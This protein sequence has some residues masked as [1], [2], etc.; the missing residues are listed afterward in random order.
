MAHSIP[1]RRKTTGHEMNL[2][3]QPHRKSYSRC[4]SISQLS[5]EEQ[6]KSLDDFKFYGAYGH[7][8]KQLDYSYHQYYR[9]ERQWLHDSIIEEYLRGANADPN[10]LPCDPWL[11]LTVGCQGAG[12]RYVIE[13]LAEENRLPLLSIV[14]VD[15]EE[16]RQLLP[17]YSSYTADP[18]LLVEDLTQKECGYIAETLTLAALQSGANV[19]LDCG[20]KDVAWYKANLLRI[21]PDFPALRVAMF[22]ITAE[23]ETVFARADHRAKETGR[24]LSR[25]LIERSL[26]VIP[27]SVEAI[28]S[29]VD[30]FCLIF[31]GEDKLELDAEGGWDRFYQTFEQTNS[32]A[33]KMPKLERLAS[34][35]DFLASS[36]PNNER[37]ESF[38]PRQQRRFSTLISSEQN[39]RSDDRKFY[40]QF[41]HVRQMLDYSYHSNYTFER[42][43]FQDAIINEF[44]HEAVVKDKNGDECTTPT[45]P[46]I[47]F[48]AGA[49]GAGKGYTMKKLVEDGLFPLIA[50]VR[51]DPDEIRRYLPEFH[52]YV[53]LSPELAGELT[54]KEAGYITEILTL[55][56]L[57]AGKNVLV[58]GSL[59]DA[60]WYG[61]YFMK[62]RVD[63]SHI[64]L[65]IIH[66][67]APPK[68]VF[69]RAADRAITTGRVVPQE[70]LEKAL[71]QVPESVKKLSPLV[72]Y[73]VELSNDDEIELVGLSC[74]TW[75]SFK[76]NW[77]Q[78]C[79]WL[80]SKARMLKKSRKI[81]S[82]NGPHSP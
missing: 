6:F 66:V 17:E 37:R 13:T 72:D 11:I 55:A 58:D 60:A 34:V 73:F 45:E 69:Q 65:A 7:I 22:H 78:S 54:R 25:E 10:S 31:N 52:L 77:M 43:I 40:G 53:K 42:Q 41:V 21:R 16:I 8:R 18:I 36:W 27:T 3:I 63:Y 74:E 59:R 64:R 68:K 48:T 30:Y 56:G 61:K 81:P 80:P 1:A 57:Q 23:L 46:W 29:D 20:L 62:L 2:N 67:T 4:F 35:T 26:S 5:T 82:A 12:K 39:H 50:F 76:A 47:V 38:R 32:L 79:A 28:K 33:E 70:L 9:K 49:M 71:K 19:I 15:Y 75:D 14:C 44:L 24:S 51:A